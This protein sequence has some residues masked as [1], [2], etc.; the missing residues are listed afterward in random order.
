M[1]PSNLLHMLLLSAYP[2]ETT[3]D[4]EICIINYIHRFTAVT[5]TDDIGFTFQYHLH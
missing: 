4:A 2:A 1:K 3:T 5:N